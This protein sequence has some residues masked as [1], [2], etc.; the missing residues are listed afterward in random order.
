ME[1]RKIVALL[2]ARAESALAAL[3]TKFGRL[4]YRIAVNILELPQDA[5]EC[6]NDAY[7]AIWNAI[8]P[9]QP[10]PLK[11]YVC[12]VGRNIAL[13]RLRDENAR[14]RCSRYDLSL[15]ELSEIIPDRSMEERLDARALGRAIDRFLQ[16]QNRE[17]RILFLR[18][19]WFGD[20]VR[21][22]ARLAG[23]KADTAYVR[24]H[25]LR[26]ELKDYLIGEELYYEG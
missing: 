13:T 22:A 16:D 14:K 8:P 7:L 19:Y 23:I 20:S 2:W 4:L 6:V 17:D 12:R 10:D 3:E 11:P 26:K 18:R 15:E 1:D 9:E 5:Q 21:E 24:L 25:R